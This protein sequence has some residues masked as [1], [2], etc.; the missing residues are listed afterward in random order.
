VVSCLVSPSLIAVGET[1]TITLTASSADHRPLT[2]SWSTTGGQLSEQGASATLTAYP[3]DGGKTISVTGTATDDRSLSMSSICTLQIKLPPAEPCV[4]IEQMSE[5]CTFQAYKKRPWRVDNACKDILDKLATRLQQNPNETL[6]IVGHTGA[7]KTS[8]AK[9]IAR[10]YEFQGGHI[11]IDGLDVRSFNLTDYHHQLGIVNQVPFLFSGTVAENIR[12]AR[13]EASDASI[14]ELARKIGNGEW[15]DN[16]PDGLNTEVSIA[17]DDCQ[18][19]LLLAVVERFENGF[20][21]ADRF[22]GHSAAVAAHALRPAAFS[23]PN[24]L[25]P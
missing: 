15:L 10:F 17:P 12:Y 19:I 25:T 7:G 16:L 4:K 21:V 22:E 14:I 23:T 5:A 3:A 8:I 13:E 18:Q 6:A 2:F 1:S 24:V 9:L 20:D 11:Y